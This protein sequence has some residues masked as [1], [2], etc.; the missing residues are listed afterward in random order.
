MYGPWS[1]TPNF[2]GTVPVK[3]KATPRQASLSRVLNNLVNGRSIDCDVG[4]IPSLAQVCSL[5][6]P[7]VDLQNVTLC[8]RAVGV[9]SSLASSGSWRTEKHR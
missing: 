1:T 4:A 7:V 8:I 6:L 9:V 2:N 3:G 5:V